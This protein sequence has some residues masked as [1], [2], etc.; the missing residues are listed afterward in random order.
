MA[1]PPLVTWYR[2][3]ES[4]AAFLRG[5]PLSGR[6]RS[7]VVPIRANGQLAFGEYRS[8]GDRRAYLAHAIIILALEGGR[9][10]EITAFLAPEAFERFGLPA[11]LEP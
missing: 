7:R 1:M 2:G 11:E 5:W 6:T 9:I 3:R 10:K 8:D 4:V